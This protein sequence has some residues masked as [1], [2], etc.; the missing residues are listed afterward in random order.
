MPIPG[1]HNVSRHHPCPICG[2]SDWCLVSDDS[3]NPTT[4]LSAICQ[5][6]ED[7]SK[8]RFGDAGHFH[9]LASNDFTQQPPRPKRTAPPISFPKGSTHNFSKLARKYQACFSD[10]DLHHLSRSLG[11][12]PKSLLRLG[13]GWINDPGA[14]SFPMYS[15]PEQIV[16]LRYRFNSGLKRSAKGCNIGLFLPNDLPAQLSHT[17]LIV[18]EG[19][20]DTAA[21]LDLGFTAIGRPDCQSKPALV[22]QLA[23]N[24]RVPMVVILADDDGPGLNGA[25]RLV[26]ML[27]QQHQPA[28]VI[29]PPQGINDAREWKARGATAAGIQ[30]V[31][32]ATL[33]NDNNHRNAG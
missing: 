10:I 19:P 3:S 33:N 2:K 11:V 13:I 5:R 24:L 1:Y 22:C 12:T 7:G 25:N 20:T 15:K 31:I 32:K 28:C 26:D 4:P 8:H 21:M 27:H 9:I 14:W 18:C 16:G 17:P 6:I 30:N 23:R 29:T